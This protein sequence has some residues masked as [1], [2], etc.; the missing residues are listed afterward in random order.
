MRQRGLEG[1]NRK[2]TPKTTARTKKEKR[3]T[4]RG[5]G[6]HNPGHPHN[7]HLRSSHDSRSQLTRLT[8][9]IGSKLAAR[10]IALFRKDQITTQVAE[11]ALSLL[12]LSPN[13]L[14]ACTLSQTPRAVVAP[15]SSQMAPPPVPRMKRTTTHPTKRWSTVYYY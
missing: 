15:F 9:L 5:Q 12:T 10:K 3:S 8:A 6:G 7:T 4:H 1:P 13:P 14:E 11:R 2:K